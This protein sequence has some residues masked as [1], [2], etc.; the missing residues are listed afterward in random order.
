[1]KLTRF[2]DEA[3]HGA[4]RSKKLETRRGRMIFSLED[5]ADLV[6]DKPTRA[7]MEALVPCDD[8]I[9]SKLISTEPARKQQL[10]WGYLGSILAERSAGP[11]QLSSCSYAGLEL[12]RGTIILQAAGDHVGERMSGGR[13]FI[14]GPAGDHLGQEMSGGGIVTQSCEDYA[15]R[16]MLGGFGVVLGSAG[17]FAGLGNHGGRIVVRG[18]C[19]ARAGWLMH[20]GSLRIGGDAGEY[21]GILMSGGK[22]LVRGR[23]GRRAGWRMKGGIIQA[24]SFGPETEDGVMGLA[25]RMA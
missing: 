15:F 9:L 11:L 16:N 25:K 14:R 1:M 6:G 21:L 12:R 22:I 2:M 20:G 10:L 18:D 13:I 19:G 24:A 3:Y 7:E 23:T 8:D 5:L 4:A 17:N